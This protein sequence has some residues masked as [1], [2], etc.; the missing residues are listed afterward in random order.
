MSGIAVVAGGR[1]AWQDAPDT[2]RVLQLALAG[3]WLLDALLQYQPMMFSR[4]F[5]Q[6]LAATAD[7]NPGFIARPI[8]WDATLIQQHAVALNVVFATIQ[9]L[10]GLGIAFRPTARL[11]LAASVAWSAGVWWFGEGLGGVLTGTASPVTGAPGAAILYALLAVLLWPAR[12]VAARA[13]RAP[14]LV[15]WLALAW[16]ALQPANRA[17]WAL[18]DTLAGMGSGEPG[19]MAALERDAA[20]LIGGHGLA[21]SIVLAAA[22]TLVAVGVYLPR[23]AAVT[24]LVLAIAIAGVIWVIGEAFGMILAGGATDPDTGPLLALL[25]LAYW[26]A[27]TAPGEEGRS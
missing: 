8:T 10:L 15:L 14:W 20:A 2:R 21:A 24:A 25:A 9:L 26:P 4:A 12:P 13:A 19:R 3:L 11:A 23:P 27:R 17:P 5:G 1:A 22:F 16:L 18:H 6:T 7:G